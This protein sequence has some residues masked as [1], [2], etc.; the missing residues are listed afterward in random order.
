MIRM[1]YPESR[2]V[3]EETVIVWAL[4]SIVNAKIEAGD[5]MQ[6]DDDS[7]LA[8]FMATVE[9]PSIEEAISLLEDEGECS[10][11]RSQLW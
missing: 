5:F 2:M 9:R 11:A 3:S 7:Q 4:D 6:D 10:F 1:T 8:A